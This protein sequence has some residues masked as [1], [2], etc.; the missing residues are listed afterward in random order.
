VTLAYVT[1]VTNA[2]YGR[3][4]LALA[5]SLRQ[6]EA[7]YP[8]VVLAS[9]NAG[10]ID[11]LAAEGC[12]I[13]E[14]ARPELSGGFLKRHSRQRQ[15]EVA[16]FTKGEKPAFHD[17][18]DNFCKLRLWQMEEY[19]KIVFIDADAIV[20]K[21]VDRLFDYPA[22]VAAPNLY[23]TL[24]D[25]DRMNAGVFVAEPG[26]AIYEAMLAEL[27]RPELFWRRTDQTFLEHFFP[28]W[29]G[30][31]YT[32]NVLQYVFFN[33]PDLWL[34][35]ELKILHY[36]YEKPWQAGHG[37]CDDLKPLIDLWWRVFE[38][39]AIPDDLPS[40]FTGAPK[41]SGQCG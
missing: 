11:E 37:K 27:D 12:R 23:E 9:E 31:P 1:L 10:F 3:G 38:G 2:D 40:P 33:L 17:P 21:N 35:A 29:H 39:G 32:Y 25:F 5:R 19:R 13:V 15:H 24:H 28:D 7:A 22:F 30:L 26:A 4:A 34:W 8:L 18:L 20:L 36:Q 14:T 6:A 16:P 41:G